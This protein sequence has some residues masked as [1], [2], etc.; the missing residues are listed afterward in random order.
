LTLML[1]LAVTNLLLCRC[2]TNDTTDVTLTESETF[3]LVF[4]KV[5]ITS[6]NGSAQMWCTVCWMMS[7]CDVGKGITTW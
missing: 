4:Y 7:A 2:I 3:G 1:V 5:F 6:K